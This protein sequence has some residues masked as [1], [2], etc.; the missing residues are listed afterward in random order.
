MDYA[1]TFEVKRQFGPE[2]PDIHAKK[3]GDNKTRKDC[4]RGLRQNRTRLIF[5]ETDTK[6]GESW[7]RETDAYKADEYGKSRLSNP[8]LRSTFEKTRKYQIQEGSQA[9]KSHGTR[10]PGEKS[11]KDII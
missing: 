5:N 8:F 1:L 4:T 11:G 2:T 7:G 6:S 3:N 10:K 9:L